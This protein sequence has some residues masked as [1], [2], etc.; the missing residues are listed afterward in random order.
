MTLE[1]KN[2]LLIERYIYSMRSSLKSE[3]FKDALQYALKSGS[4][5]EDTNAISDFI[6]EHL[7][8]FAVLTPSYEL[9]T[10]D[11]IDE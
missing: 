9:A 3:R 1:G 7:A 6:I 10:I 2:E 8:L 5:F 4:L 11:L